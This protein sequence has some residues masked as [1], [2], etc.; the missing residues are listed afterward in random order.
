LRSDLVAVVILIMVMVTVAM[1]LVP[2]IVMAVVVM[3]PLATISSAIVRA[4]MR[5]GVLSRLA[6][7]IVLIALGAIKSARGAGDR[8][9]VFVVGEAIQGD[10]ARPN[11][12]VSPEVLV[13]LPAVGVSRNRADSG[14]YLQSDDSRY[15]RSMVLL[16]I[17]YSFN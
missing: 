2:A 14:D 15:S 12:G 13:V 4:R 6:A 1:V 16:H 10:G 7:S 5:V 17:V 9:R 11:R 3:T 8:Q